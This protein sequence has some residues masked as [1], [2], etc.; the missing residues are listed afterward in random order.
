[1]R[2]CRAGAFAFMVAVMIGL[3]GCGGSDEKSDEPPAGQASIGDA[4]R[5]GTPGAA[6][7]AEAEE[8]DGVVQGSPSLQELDSLPEAGVGSSGESCVSPPPD[9]TA[10][11]LRSVA[12]ATLCLLNAERAARGLKP[13]RME[14]R[15]TAAAKGHSRD[16]VKRRF[17][18]HVSPDGGTFDQRI[19]KAGY[20]RRART[21]V[22]GENIGSGVGEAASPRQ[23]VDAWMNS[24]P[25]KANILHSRF[26]EIGVGIVL[27][28]PRSSSTPALTYSTNFG[29]RQ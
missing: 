18:A 10:A 24:R 27:G 19:R 5:A 29:L 16:M 1:M 25:H 15:L 12:R 2:L 4:V 3:A 13:L 26:A 6:D 20:T 17:F 9:V 22:I 7:V 23:I 28:S 11:D 21:F 14:T 8:S